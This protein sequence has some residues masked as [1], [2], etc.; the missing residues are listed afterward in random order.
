[1]AKKKILYDEYRLDSVEWVASLQ[2]Y[3]SYLNGLVAEG[4]SVLNTRYGY[5][6]EKYVVAL[7]ERYETDEEQT[8]REQKEIEQ[9]ALMK[10]RE[11]ETLDRLKKKY[12]S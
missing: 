2:H 6:D 3:I 11:L 4:Y 1:M 7:K 12:E 9:K 5:A 8:S 10:Q